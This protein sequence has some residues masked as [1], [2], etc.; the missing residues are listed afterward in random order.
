MN[1]VTPPACVALALVLLAAI[2]CGGGGTQTLTVFADASLTGT[3]GSL[4]KTFEAAHPG[5]AVRFDFG[6]SGALAQRIV[7]GAPTD[8]FAAAGT[9][10]MRESGAPSP[11]V[12]ARDSLQIA[13]PKGNPAHVADLKDLTAPGVRVALCAESAPCGAGA[14]AALAAAGVTLTSVGGERDGAKALAK[15]RLGEADAA[16]VYRTDIRAAGAVDGALEAVDLPETAGAVEDYLIATVPG[17]E[18]LALTR[19]FVDLVLSSE[20]R[21]VLAAAGF[22][23]VTG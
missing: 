2:G 16:L 17:T 9:A 7:Q 20:G 1:H 8:L 23:P 21:K 10:A 15:V 13:V 3:F 12:F 22:T 14:R 6:G 5:V 18:R 19:E 4:G 11:R